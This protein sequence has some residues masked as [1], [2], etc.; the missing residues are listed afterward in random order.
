VSD[1]DRDF[2]AVVTDIRLESRIGG[3]A[4]WQMAL[5][6]T[7]FSAASPV[8]VLTAVAPSGA[9]LEV[10]VLSVVEEGGMVWHVVDKPLTEGTELTG[11]IG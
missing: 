2:T 5:D 7:L 10:P 3:V 11:R 9:R 4:R 8:G 6:R 1:D